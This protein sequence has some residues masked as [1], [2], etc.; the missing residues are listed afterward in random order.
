MPA[1]PGR[2]LAVAILLLAQAR[3]ASR[4]DLTIAD[5]ESDA[6][7]AGWSVTGDAFAA[8]PRVAVPAGARLAWSGGSGEAATGTLLSAEFRVERRFLSFRVRGERNAPAVTG[9]ELL[10]GGQVVRAAAATEQPSFLFS[11]AGDA[12]GVMHRRTWDVSAFAGR[13][14]RLRINDRSPRGAIAIDDV[15]QSD[16]AASAPIDAS[17]TG[18]ETYRPQFH[19]TALAG[20]LNDPNGLLYYRGTWHLFHQFAPPD[21][22]GLVWG[23][24]TSTDLVHW[25]HRPPSIP[26]DPQDSYYSGSGVVDRWNAS[27]LKRG[28][29]DPLLLFYSVR[30]PGPKLVEPPFDPS[31]RRMTQE[32]AYSLDGGTTWRRWEKNPMLA[33]ADYRDRDPKVVYHEP[34]KSW[35]QF[36]S[37]SR[38]NA[39]R[40][41]A[42][43]GV[44]Q[45]QN[46]RDW[47]LVQQLGPDAWFWECPDLFE[48]PIDGDR[49]KTK[50]LLL[51]GSGD[52][53]I[54]H[55]DARGFQREAGP[56][57][58]KFGGNYYATQTFQD[59]PHGR[60]V[61]IG[62]MNT[63]GKRDA[64]NAFPGMP[65]NQQM[66]VP[67]EI[68]LRS[69]PDGPRLFREPARELE[70]L[71]LR[72]L[73]VQPGP[74][75]PGTNALAGLDAELLD[76]EMEITPGTARRIVLQLRGTEIAFDV[77]K[78]TLHAFQST[79]P[80][81]LRDGRLHLRVL[82]D[83]TSVEVFGNRGQADIS[84]VFF[85]DPAERSLVLTTTGGT[86]TVLRLVAHELKSAWPD[87]TRAPSRN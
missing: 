65:F 48:L 78:Q 2:R 12:L 38:N 73:P 36:L 75:A 30:P 25:T 87:D 22:P 21:L 59:A 58:T 85:P 68:T 26:P 81:P 80:L 54:G 3:A 83:R 42:T 20:W 45:S 74:L 53:L 32:M 27:G 86:A 34:S 76:L 7:P 5:F 55:F 52:Y 6:W 50:W 37:L 9:A 57:R 66:S 60:R 29:H 79:A 62:W 77:A 71:R 43:Y 41:N 56:I 4:P 31:L 39:N 23:H 40:P 44:F 10:V 1:F 84:G 70:A 17:Q 18:R 16:T 72:E 61:Q 15:I 14:A 69:T 8:G 11:D 28:D 47:K 82:L 67:R 24:A 49:S 51:K 64:V 33:T 19:Y 13:T 35:F 46:L 63:G